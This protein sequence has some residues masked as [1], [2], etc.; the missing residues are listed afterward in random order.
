MGLKSNQPRKLEAQ[1]DTQSLNQWQSTFRSYYRCCERYG[2][3]FQPDFT[4]NPQA[5]NWGITTD[6]AEGKKRTAAVLRQDLQDF[7]AN[8]GSYLP[9]NYAAKKLLKVPTSLQTVWETI[10]DIYDADITADSFLDFTF[11]KKN[12]AE[13]YRSYWERLVD[14]VRD[15][16]AVSPA[17]PAEAIKVEEAVAPRG[18]GEG[19]TVTLLD[20]VTV[21]WLN[22]INPRLLAIVRRE[23][24]NELKKGTRISQLVR[25]VAKQIDA[26]L[27]RDD[28]TDKVQSVSSRSAESYGAS[29]LEHSEEM[30]HSQPGFDM[31][32]YIKVNRIRGNRGQRSSGFRGGRGGRSSSYQRPRFFCT[33]C[34]FLSRTLDVNIDTNHDPDRCAR[35]KVAVNIVNAGE[36]EENQ[37]DQYENQDFYSTA[38]GMKNQIK[39]SSHLPYLQELPGQ[40]KSEN[41][42]TSSASQA[43]EIS[44]IRKVLTITEAPQFSFLLNIN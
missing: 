24:H 11:I 20:L 44:Q 25:R 28:H 2:Y 34:A 10:Y 35:K 23:Y 38:T 37:Q 41:P 12:E 21:W 9:F 33:H 8:L 19:L 6:E 32:G 3:F 27:D 30:Y 36:D 14:H 4:W 15:H 1:E 17:L 31:D 18:A 5:E 22:N 7:L 26:L 13:T 16:L 42:E 39:P 29:A 43:V 40:S